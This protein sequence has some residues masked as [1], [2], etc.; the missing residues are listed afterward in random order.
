MCLI[1]CSL[2]SF[3]RYQDRDQ[4]LLL[5]KSL[6]WQQWLW[7][8]SPVDD[9]VILTS[10]TPKCAICPIVS[11]SQGSHRTAW[12]EKDLKDYL[13][14][15]G[16]VRFCVMLRELEEKMCLDQSCSSNRI[17]TCTMMSQQDTLDISVM[18]I[19]L[20]FSMKLKHTNFMH[21]YQIT[22]SAN[23]NNHR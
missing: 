1:R 11:F 4:V 17:K 13:R 23:R 9:F 18:V 15:S 5:R 20:C 8:L 21:A 12:V 19:H 14:S 2:F 6:Q 7:A 10:E 22:F 3:P 16:K